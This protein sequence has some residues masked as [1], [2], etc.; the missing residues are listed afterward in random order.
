MAAWR[1]TS[2]PIRSG[3]DGGAHVTVGDSCVPS[4]VTEGRLLGSALTPSCFR[5]GKTQRARCGE[6]SDGFDSSSRPMRMTTCGATG[7]KG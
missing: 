7:R 4:A 5:Q 3:T 1:R 2:I 6:S